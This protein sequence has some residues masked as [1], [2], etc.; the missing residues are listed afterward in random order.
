MPGLLEPDG[1][2]RSGR[3]TSEVE[4]PGLREREHVVIGPVVV[5]EIHR[6]PGHD[7]ENVRDERLVAL[8]Q[9][10][11][12]L[13]AGIEGRARRRVEI[14]HGPAAVGRAMTGVHAEL[15]DV[16]PRLVIGASRPELHPAPDHAVGGARRLAA[17]RG[18][19]KAQ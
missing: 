11:A 19:W 10:G 18:T 3:I 4:G 8:V 1:L 2:R 13:V 15:G 6:R 17:G 12:R 16:R 9:P 5:G 14:D 7:R